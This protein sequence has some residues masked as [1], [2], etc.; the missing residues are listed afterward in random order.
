MKVVI[1]PDSFKESLPASQVARAMAEGVRQVWPEAE[2]DCCPMADGGQG[3]VEAMV[4]ATAGRML[5]AEAF[6]PLCEPRSAAYGLLGHG[7]IAVIEMA[8]AAG[9]ELLPPAQRNPLKT[10]TFGVGKLILAALDQG[11]EEIILGIGGSAT[12]DGGVGCAQALGAVFLNKAGRPFHC[13]MAGGELNEIG[14]IDISDI[15]PRLRQV[16]LRIACDV[17][18]PLCGPGGAAA[19]YGPQKGATPEMVAH[20]DA[21][22]ANLAAVLRRA[23]GV[24][25]ERGEE[26]TGRAEHAHHIA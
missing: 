21:G 26:F 17:T 13:G 25:V 3:T 12:V 7:R 9:L 8:A 5:A 6:G 14:R 16:R 15:E 18:N 11:V 20:L 19:V 2:I 10:T 24:D 22:L 1:A 23:V 4:S